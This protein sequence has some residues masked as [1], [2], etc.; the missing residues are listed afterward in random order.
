MQVIARNKKAK[1]DY[2]ILD[3]YEAGIVLKG[4]EIKSVRQGKVNIKDTYCLPR[5]GQ[6]RIMNMHISKYKH[7]NQFNHDERRTRKLLMHKK[8]II[9][10]ENKVNQDRVTVI[11]LSVYIKDGLCKIEIAIAKGKKQYDKRQ[12]LKADQAKRDLQKALKNYG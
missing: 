9:K 3:T 4:T 7:G 11:P 2:D 8:E 1:H 6:I 10:I 12:S 5:N